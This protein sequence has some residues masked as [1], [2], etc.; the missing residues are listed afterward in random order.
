MTKKTKKNQKTNTKA[1]VTKVAVVAHN[2]HFMEILKKLLAS[3]TKEKK[4]TVTLGQIMASLKDQGLIFLIALLAFP[5]S[6]PIPTPPGFTTLFGIPLAILTAQLIYNLDSPWL[7]KW[8]AN[9]EI[10]LSTFE[11]FVTKA[12]PF[13]AKLAK[14]L[15]PRNPYFTSV[16]MEKIVGV[17]AFLCALSITLPILFGNAIP[18]IGVFIMALGL[19]YKDGLTTL[20]GMIISCL[21]IAIATSVVLAVFWLG[22]GALKHMV[23]GMNP[24]A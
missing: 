7:P 2:I 4:E 14:F 24:F 21:G 16:F 3:L 20:F 9:R 8:I 12:E 5:T 17:I 18:S 1:T 19:L 15:K 11:M 13:F 6:I 23:H 22:M 10:K